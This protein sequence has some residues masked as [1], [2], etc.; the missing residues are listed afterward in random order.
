MLISHI[1]FHSLDKKK[2]N[3]QIRLAKSLG[4]EVTNCYVLDTP[5]SVASE[6]LSAEGIDVNYIGDFNQKIQQLGNRLSQDWIELLSKQSRFSVWE[7]FSVRRS[8]VTTF[9]YSTLLNRNREVSAVYDDL[10]RILAI[11][12]NVKIERSSCLVVSGN[13]HFL[14]LCF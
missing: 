12:E 13:H 3:K 7:S 6:I 14:E 10:V 11:M 1:V 9:Q 5:K 4:L 2:L 8:S